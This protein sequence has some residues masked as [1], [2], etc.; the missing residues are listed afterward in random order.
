MHANFNPDFSRD[1]QDSCLYNISRDDGQN[2]F[3][4]GK[5][6]IK[7]LLVLEV[8]EGSVAVSYVII[9]VV[10]SKNMS[11]YDHIFLTSTQ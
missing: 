4:G 8:V 6:P 1:V 3:C 5:T 10:Q 9:I 2:E 7:T 11:P